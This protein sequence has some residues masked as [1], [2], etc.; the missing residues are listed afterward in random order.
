MKRN[1]TILF[2]TTI[3]FYVLI[4]SVGS[5]YSQKKNSDLLGFAPFLTHELNETDRKFY[6]QRYFEN[7]ET[8][9][10]YKI[11]KI[12]KTKS[13]NDTINFSGV[14]KIK[15]KLRPSFLKPELNKL[16]PDSFKRIS[17]YGFVGS[18]LI[19]NGDTNLCN[20]DLE[21][22]E[23]KPY[24][25]METT[26]DTTDQS[27]N[28]GISYLLGLNWNAESIPSNIKKIKTKYNKAKQSEKDMAFSTVYESMLGVISAYES[29][30]AMDEQYRKKLKKLTKFGFIMGT[31]GS[32]FFLVI[33][34]KFL[35]KQFK[36]FISKGAQTLVDVY[37]AEQIS[38]SEKDEPY[39]RILTAKQALD[40][41]LKFE[42]IFSSVEDNFLLSRAEELFLGYLL[43]FFQPIS[44]SSIPFP[45]IIPDNLPIVDSPNSKLE[46]E[47]KDA[48]IKASKNY[49]D[50]FVGSFANEYLQLLEKN[51]FSLKED[52]I[53]FLIGKGLLFPKEP[54]EN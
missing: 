40:K 30:D 36:G 7:I 6:L 16:V 51:D 48:Y 19:T 28:P 15:N 21:A 29:G 33:D 42:S 37:L 13:K 47:F 8:I 25:S 24:S 23:L 46:K 39:R 41:L 43:Y 11:D 50:S 1:S 22:P 35:S 14:L 3:L 54:I 18:I 27:K 12:S 34:Y 20:F 44:E 10:V 2:K 53:K 4:T 17:T 49:P 26:V 52:V 38:P 45:F 31:T 5:T 9:D 32:N